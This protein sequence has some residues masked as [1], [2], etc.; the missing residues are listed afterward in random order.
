MT[1]EEQKKYM[2]NCSNG[3]KSLDKMLS[4]MLEDE[5]LKNDEELVRIQEKVK[6]QVN[7]LDDVSNNST[8]R[9]R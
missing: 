8:S 6:N 4:S 2:D 5:D 7:V 9:K 1:E 3:L